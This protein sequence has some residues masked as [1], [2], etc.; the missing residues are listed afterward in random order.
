[1]FAMQATTHPNYSS[2]SLYFRLVTKLY[3]E[4]CEKGFYLHYGTLFGHRHAQQ[5]LL[6]VGEIEIINRINLREF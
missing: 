1:M 5:K 4:M 3:L 6:S 2:S